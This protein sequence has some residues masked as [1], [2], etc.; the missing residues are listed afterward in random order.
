[1]VTIWIELYRKKFKIKAGYLRNSVNQISANLDGKG[2]EVRLMVNPEASSM[3][4]RIIINGT[5]WSQLDINL[6]I[7]LQRDN[8][9]EADA[10]QT[11]VFVLSYMQISYLCDL[12]I[13]S[14]EPQDLLLHVVGASNNGDCSNP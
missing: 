14:H 8:L 2:S 3:E 13:V 4:T 9:G 1:M 7:L 11:L 12:L 5:S 6:I 10:G